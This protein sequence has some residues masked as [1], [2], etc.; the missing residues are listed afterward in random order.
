MRI[1][2]SD[3]ICIIGYSG[4]G[5]STLMEFLIDDFNFDSV[6]IDPVSRFSNRKNIRYVAF[7]STHPYRVRRRIMDIP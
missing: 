4:A 7:Q 2:S 1:N 5:K 3:K 6:V